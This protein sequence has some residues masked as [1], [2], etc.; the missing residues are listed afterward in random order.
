MHPDPGAEFETPERC[1]ILEAWNVPEDRDV[2]IARATVAP[3][4]RTQLHRLRG[5]V[6]RYLVVAGRGRVEV[7]ERAAEAV[8]PGDVVVIPA[9]APQRIEN[10]GEQDLVFYCICSPAFE[11]ER[12]EALE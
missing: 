8:G 6:E 1:R 2:S 4:V 3:G 7:G 11:Q 9:G 10:V 12:Y 5:T